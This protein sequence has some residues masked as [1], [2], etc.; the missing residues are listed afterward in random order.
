[1][2]F[3]DKALLVNLDIRQWTAHKHDKNI[4]RKI[5]EEH[6][7]TEA[8]RYNKVL[9]KK[10]SLKE[11]QSIASAAREFLYKKTLPWGDNGDRVLPSVN[12][13]D[14]I[15]EYNGYKTKYD[16][17]ADNFINNY[18]NL[19]NEAR[20]RLNGM[21]EESDYPNVGTLRTRFGMDINFM[22]IPDSKDFRLQL[23]EDEVNALR[24]SIEQQINSRITQ[25]TK[26]IYYRIKE[27]VGHMVE[28]LSD[29]EAV[30]RN[31]L[32]EN[33]R[34]LV[35]TLPRLNFTGDP[36][37]NELVNNMRGLLVKPETLRNSSIYRAAKAE[38]AKAILD[39]VS[40][41]LGD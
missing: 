12:Y 9:I 29:K 39:K 6:N 2:T 23:E 31:T 7:A 37:V 18:P 22:A 21:F 32:V 27:A 16:T 4:S 26:N 3:T 33:I 24:T 34:E 19:M 13:F 28:R 41:F 11:I 25:A 38:E 35:E 20:L 36:D 5:E 40:A 17:A 10:E 14:F 8:G 30:F 1:M 15:A